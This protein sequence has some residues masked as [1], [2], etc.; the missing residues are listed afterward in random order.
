MRV[1]G[2]LSFEKQC[3]GVALKNGTG[4]TEELEWDTET[5]TAWF[6]IPVWPHVVRVGTSMGLE[7]S[8][9]WA[10]V[11]IQPCSE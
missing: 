2:R 3:L 10:P 11:T 7:P 8:T 4:G 6:F 5:F 1:Q 9:L